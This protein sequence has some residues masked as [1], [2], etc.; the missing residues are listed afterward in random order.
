VL[1]PQSIIDVRFAG[2]QS[3]LPLGLTF[4]CTMRWVVMHEATNAVI[5]FCFVP[6]VTAFT[7]IV[8]TETTL[9][10]NSCQVLQWECY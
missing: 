4:L 1:T 8:D 10:M 6:A 5:F 3:D 9:V 2:Y 7:I